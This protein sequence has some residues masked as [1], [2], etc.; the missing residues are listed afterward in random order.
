MIQRLLKSAFFSSQF[1]NESRI[2][3]ICR[4]RST[5]Y[6]KEVWFNKTM[7]IITGCLYF[8]FVTVNLICKSKETVKFGVTF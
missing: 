7:S 3:N 8:Y 2:S 1:I 4:I 6:Y 5:L